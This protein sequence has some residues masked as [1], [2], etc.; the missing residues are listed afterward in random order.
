M[1]SWAQEK[2]EL[3]DSTTDVIEY[4]YEMFRAIIIVI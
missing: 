4:F 3:I 2:N 1:Q